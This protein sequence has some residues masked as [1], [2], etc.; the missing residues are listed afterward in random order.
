MDN[1]D[2][3]GLGNG[4]HLRRGRG[5][6]VTALKDFEVDESERS[7][8]AAEVS[9]SR[10]VAFAVRRSPPRR[11]GRVTNRSSL[12]PD[13]KARTFFLSASSFDFLSNSRDT[14]G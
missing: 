11:Q 9:F 1:I 10:I 7:R 3:I 5:G 13:L 12:S 8:W 6:S 2:G 4:S 14:L